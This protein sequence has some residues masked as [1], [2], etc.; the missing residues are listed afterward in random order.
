MFANHTKALMA[1]GFTLAMAAPSQAGFEIDITENDKLIF[2]GYIKLDARY[3]DGDIAYRDFWIGSGTPLEEDATQFRLFANETRFNTK[4]IHGDVTGFIE[5]DFLGGGGNEVISNSFHPR[6]RHAFI[7]YKGVTAGQTW[8]TLM[9]TSAIPETADF[10]GATVGLAF[11]RQGQIRYS[12]GGFAVSIENPESWGGDTSNDRLP[13]V[14]AK[15]TLKGDWG[16]VSLA[17]IG[18]ELNTLGGNRETAFGGSLAAKINTFGK[19]DLRLQLHLGELGRYISVGA[20]QDL[21]GEEVESVTAYLAAYRHF[22]TDTLRSTFLYGRVE[23]DESNADNDQWSVNLFQD[24]NKYLSVGVEVGNFAMNEADADS[25]YGQ[26]SMRY[27][28]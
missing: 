15:Y 20:A 28:L 3:V 10:A 23:T 4:Y 21:V 13:D 7:S 11:I 19:D 5:M 26:F 27:A 22:W 17:G 24:L 1:A 6:I 16:N 2:G 25:F 9:N 18:R 14:I 12:T 8:S